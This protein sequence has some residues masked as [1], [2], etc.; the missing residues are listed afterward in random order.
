MGCADDQI[1]TTTN[2]WPPKTVPTGERGH[3]THRRAH[4]G[5]NSKKQ[6]KLGSSERDFNDRFDL[7]ADC[8]RLSRHSSIQGIQEL[9]PSVSIAEKLANVVGAPVTSESMANPKRHSLDNGLAKELQDIFAALEQCIELRSA[10]MHASLQCP[11]DNPKDS[12][13]W[14]IYP[15]PPK[16]SYPVAVDAQGNDI[17][18]SPEEFNMDDVYIPG[19]DAE[20]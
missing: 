6:H 9:L 5:S 8:A 20:P 1:I 17:K 13:D 18:E 11:G 10:Y 15:A 7:A 4:T 12:A 16:P 3:G 19:L 14:D 2:R